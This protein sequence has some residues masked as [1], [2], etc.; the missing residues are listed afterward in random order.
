MVRK[1]DNLNTP[2]GAMRMFNYTFLHWIII[3]SFYSATLSYSILYLNP[4]FSYLLVCLPFSFLVLNRDTIF[5]TVT[6]VFVVEVFCRYYNFLPE[7]TA[8]LSDILLAVVIVTNFSSIKFSDRKKILL[9]FI[10]FILISISSIIINNNLSILN[11]VGLRRALF[12]FLLYWALLMAIATTQR[13]NLLHKFLY[14]IVLLQ[15]IFCLAEFMIMMFFRNNIK[16]LMLN[17]YTPIVIDAACGTFGFGS[18]GVLSIFLLMYVPFLFFYEKEKN[19]QFNKLKYLYITSPL[20]IT[21]SGGALALSSIVLVLVLL[22][23][24]QKL[25]KTIFVYA[26]IASLILGGIFLGSTFFLKK[27]GVQ[28]ATLNQFEYV[29]SKLSFDSL[30]RGNSEERGAFV[31]QFGSILII[32]RLASQSEGGIWFGMGPGMLSRTSITEQSSTTTYLANRFSNTELASSNFFTRTLAEYGLAGVLCIVGFCCSYIYLAIQKMSSM[33]N[34]YKGLFIS[35]GVFLV[36][37][38]YVEGWMNRQLGA[39][40]IILAF[41]VDFFKT[42]RTTRQDSTVSCSSKKL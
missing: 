13:L 40:F 22:L 32:S 3:L 28:L 39:L 34:L 7:K 30:T 41:T 11:V 16:G 2:Q 14:R 36:S 10:L 4:I 37:F 23:S 9:F 25:Y 27:S 38:S 6:F 20:L 21:F 19:I 12:P 31:G 42:N 26:P 8:W 35:T 29:T 1:T 33:P 18:S 5:F 15:P 24:G 17:G